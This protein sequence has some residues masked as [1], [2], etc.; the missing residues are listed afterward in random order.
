MD[1]ASPD[2]AAG[3]KAEGDVSSVAGSEADS[4]SP[5][6]SRRQGEQ[7]HQSRDTTGQDSSPMAAHDSSQV[8]LTLPQCSS[9]SLS[10]GG[11]YQRSL[12]T[13]ENT[14]AS[15]L[16]PVATQ[17]VSDT[18]KTGKTCSEGEFRL[19][20]SP[21][22]EHGVRT[23][24]EDAVGT[25]QRNIATMSMGFS[26]AATTERLSLIRDHGGTLMEKEGGESDGKRFRAKINPASNNQAEEELRKQIR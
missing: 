3:S 13:K 23:D 10:G 4:E 8:G 24:R 11:T 5:L 21:V 20:S 19:D 14:S 25:R 17:A 6:A 26:L 15:V 7:T 2:A 12:Q 1:K 22:D 18:R 9:T 16:E